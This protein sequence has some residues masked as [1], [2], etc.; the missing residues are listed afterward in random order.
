M[1]GMKEAPILFVIAVGDDRVG[2]GCFDY[3][4]VIG[5]LDAGQLRRGL[6]ELERYQVFVWNANR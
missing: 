3:L 4:R 1:M 6:C 2:L 5:E